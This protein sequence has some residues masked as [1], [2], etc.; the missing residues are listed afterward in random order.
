M[1]MNKGMALF[2]AHQELFHS[3][4]LDLVFFTF[5]VFLRN[6]PNQLLQ[7]LWSANTEEG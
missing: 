5:I 4:E 1:S 6:Q 7:D 3:L 2:R